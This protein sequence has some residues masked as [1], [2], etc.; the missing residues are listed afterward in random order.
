MTMIWERHV[1]YWCISCSALRRHLDTCE[2]SSEA[3]P[4]PGGSGTRG[5]EGK[6]NVS[7]KSITLPVAREVG[8]KGHAYIEAHAQT[9]LKS[10][11]PL[12]KYW[13]TPASGHTYARCQTAET[14][15][16]VC[17]SSIVHVMYMLIHYF[18]S[19]CK[20]ANY[21]QVEESICAAFVTRS[22]NYVTRQE[23]LCKCF[24]TRVVQ[25]GKKMRQNF[26]HKIYWIFFSSHNKMSTKAIKYRI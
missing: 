10:C 22:F 1:A 23:Q 26:T 15:T 4:A 16:N 6:K 2:K 13:L 14:H 7:A 8:I 12:R 21:K 5:W 25:K 17:I 24:V 20:K 11:C 3:E 18:R 19:D 9:T